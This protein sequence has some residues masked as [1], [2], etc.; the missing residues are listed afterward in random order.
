MLNFFKQMFKKPEVKEIT[1][2]E[3][4]ESS[5]NLI[6]PACEKV[7]DA[8]KKLDDAE[9]MNPNI[10]PQERNVME[11]N[12]ETHCKLTRQLVEKAESFE[13]DQ[14]YFDRMRDTTLNWTK[15][16]HRPLMVL[17]HFFEKEVMQVGKEV[18]D[19]SKIIDDTEQAY[20][21]IIGKKEIEQKNEQKQKLLARIKEIDECV[22]KI[23]SSK[24]DE[25]EKQKQQKLDLL[26][27]EKVE[28][29]KQKLE[30]LRAGIKEQEQKIIEPFLV[31][32]GPLRKL[33]K[34]KPVYENLIH[35]YDQNPLETLIT[36]PSLRIAETLMAL[37]ESIKTDEIE[38]K[39]KNK[40]LH[41][42]NE[43]DKEMLGHFLREYAIVKIQER[44]KEEFVEYLLKSKEIVMAKDELKQ[45][46]EQRK[47]DEQD[48][49][50]LDKEKQKHKATLERLG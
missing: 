9:L 46:Q 11:G 43:L 13:E 37:R 36:D 38:V 7:L 21:K 19:L 39:N 44:E 41:A 2:E 27:S 33:A 32:N 12:R 18:H 14:K 24:L 20:K 50:D 35:K 47:Q 26:L 8:V 15:N 10:S 40:A 48:L 17:L 29:E 42:I 30:A 25:S 1:S 22:L 6:K 49:H 4:L 34:L 16:T 45:I 23:T 5:K 3:A 28:K 31:L